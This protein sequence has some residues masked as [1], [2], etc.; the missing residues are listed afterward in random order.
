MRIPVLTVLTAAII[1]T[2]APARAQTYDPADPAIQ[3]DVC[4][5]NG[6]ECGFRR[7]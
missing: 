4:D 7:R 2:A 1:F 5:G 3:T 6:I